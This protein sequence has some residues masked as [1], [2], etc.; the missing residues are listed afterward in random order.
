M[1]TLTPQEKMH[2]VINL[3][4]KGMKLGELPIAAAIFHG[5]ELLSSAYTTEKQDGKWLVH[6]ELKALIDLDEKKIPIKT[7]KECELFTNLEP[8][9]MCLGTALNSFIGTVY[10]A[11]EAPDDGAVGVVEKHYKSH[12]INGLPAWHFP[13]IKVGLLREASIDLFREFVEVN[14]GAAGTDFAK[15]IATLK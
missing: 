9:L 8:C 2:F 1:A 4:K 6:A 13:D 12:K 5:D 7:R 15:T 10:Y 11:V 14:E 3:A